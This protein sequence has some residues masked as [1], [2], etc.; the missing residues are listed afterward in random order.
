MDRAMTWT[1]H[2]VLV[3]GLGV[4]CAASGVA[5]TCQTAWGDYSP[6]QLQAAVPLSGSA[7]TPFSLHMDNVSVVRWDWH[8]FLADDSLCSGPGPS[9]WASFSPFSGNVPAQQNQTQGITVTMNAQSFGRGP[10]RAYACVSVDVFPMVAVPV[11]MAVDDVI[12]DNGFE[13]GDTPW[14]ASATD[15]GDLSITG[16]A[17]M[18]GARGLQAFVNDTAPLY[19]EDD[20]PSDEPRYRARFA[21]NPS[22]F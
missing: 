19:V 2:G 13:L 20:T 6:C 3:L 22:D 12:F 16:A 17:A 11:E 9:T 10:K 1:V 21:L 15:G 4:G 8:V 7:T 14:T 18:S 5:D